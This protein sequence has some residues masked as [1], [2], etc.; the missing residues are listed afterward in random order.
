[1]PGIL[2]AA[3][4]LPVLSLGMD[5][6]VEAGLTDLE[7]LA[8]GRVRCAECEETYRTLPTRAPRPD[9]EAQGVE[10]IRKPFV[11]NACRPPHAE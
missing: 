9:V 6:D 8:N 1:M 10:F 2:L 5:D 11:C 7:L 3:V 4:S